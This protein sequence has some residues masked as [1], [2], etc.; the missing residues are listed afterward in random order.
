MIN[1]ELLMGSKHAQQLWKVKRFTSRI[2]NIIFDEAHCI[3]QWGSF[4]KEY[5]QVGL[6][7]YIIPEKIPFYVVS[8][9]LPKPV[10]DDISSILQLRQSRTK[11]FMRSND[12]PEVSL[13]IKALI[14]PANSF[15]DLACLLPGDPLC[16]KRPPRFLVYFDNIKEAEVATAYLQTR[17]RKE[18][19][20]R[21]AY[22]HATMTPGYR[23]NE[24]LMIQSGERWGIISTDAFGLVRFILSV[25]TIQSH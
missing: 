20:F 13:A 22:C 2:I 6:L 23:T 15:K 11:Y 18:D 12:R 5:T 10:L 17:L 8:A 21:V 1:P 9:T 7:R 25:N 4:R 16:V 24:L 19:K 14:H 3:S